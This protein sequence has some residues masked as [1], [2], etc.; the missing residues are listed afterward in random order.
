MHHLCLDTATAAGTYFHLTNEA[1]LLLIC[2]LLPVLENVLLLRRKGSAPE[3]WWP[4]D[5]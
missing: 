5:L 3:A 4:F 1:L 2:Q